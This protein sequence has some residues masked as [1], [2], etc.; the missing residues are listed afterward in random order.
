M[1]TAAAFNPHPIVGDASLELPSK[2]IC[3][4]IDRNRDKLLIAEQ[5]PD[6]P[7][8]GVVAALNIVN[9]HAARKDHFI[10]SRP[11]QL[12]G[13]ELPILF[14]KRSPD[15]VHRLSHAD[16]PRSFGE[17]LRGDMAPGVGPA[18][19]IME[20]VSQ[21]AFDVGEKNLTG[22]LRVLIG[23]RG[24]VDQ[25]IVQRFLGILTVNA[26]DA[27]PVEIEVRFR[28]I[29]KKHM[30]ADWTNMFPLPFPELFALAEPRPVRWANIIVTPIAAARRENDCLFQGILGRSLE[31][32]PGGFCPGSGSDARFE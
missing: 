19:V 16:Q 25:T 6:E 10:Q 18:L 12:F 8:R 32:V 29:A 11:E 26:H 28:M 4:I 5:Q 22:F 1:V 24:L 17:R 15:Q 3:W 2:S 13:N 9:P 21:I 7:D 23:A 30:M 31:L 20:R 14:R 27:V